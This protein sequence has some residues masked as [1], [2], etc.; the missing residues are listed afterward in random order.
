MTAVPEIDTEQGYRGP[1]SRSLYDQLVA[2]EGQVAKAIT[3]L[4]QRQRALKKAVDDLLIPRLVAWRERFEDGDVPRTP[5]GWGWV[6]DEEPP[7]NWWRHHD[8]AWEFCGVQHGP[9]A[10]MAIFKVWLMTSE[11]ERAHHYQIPASFV[12]GEGGER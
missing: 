10:Q 2:L 1:V 5:E 9:F 11:G 7:R 6:V 3:D 4:E 8:P 12:F